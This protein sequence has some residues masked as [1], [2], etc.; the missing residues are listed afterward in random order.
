LWANILTR[1]RGYLIGVAYTLVD[2]GFNF[3][4][5]SRET[6]LIPLICILMTYIIYRRRLPWKFIL[7]LLP[8]VMIAIGFMDRYRQHLYKTAT[9]TNRI[10]FN[11]IRRGIS[12][13]V[14]DT[15]QEG[16]ISET[17]LRGVARFDDMQSIARI[18]Y[19]VP[20]EVDY[21]RGETF[22]LILPG[23][24]P[25]ALWPDKPSLIVPA[26]RW[27][28][29]REYGSSPLTTVGEGYLN[30]GYPGVVFA[31]LICAIA[32]QLTNRFMTSILYNT[33]CIPVYV[34]AVAIVA[35]IHTAALC[36]LLTTFPKLICLALLV[37]LFTRRR[38][39]AEQLSA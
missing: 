36:S 18:H 14:Y 27:F 21:L 23:F 11:E 24:V 5:G 6:T 16:G 13:A 10:D 29:T 20:D 22:K 31:A 33:A 12:K 26:N 30:Y 4:S 37:H 1:R 7:V 35:R 39:S 32:L 38:R 25:R 34:V 28:F 8:L 17:I 2:L 15:E 3:M 19:G 9:A